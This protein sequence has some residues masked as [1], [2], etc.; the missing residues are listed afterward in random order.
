LS[1]GHSFFLEMSAVT[2][3]VG[4]R[5]DRLVVIER[6]GSQNAKAAWLCRCRCGEMTVVV[7]AHLRENLTKS[8]GCLQ[9]ETQYPH[10]D[11]G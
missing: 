5:F 11:K 2:E 6:A 10:A 4:K 8:C 9:R 7:G 1:N 3:M